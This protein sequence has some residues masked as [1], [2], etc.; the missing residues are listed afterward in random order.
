MKCI[1]ALLV[2]LVLVS[3]GVQA[4]QQLPREELPITAGS[5]VKIRALATT[6]SQAIRSGT[7]DLVI[8]QSMVNM[9]VAAQKADDT[10]MRVATAMSATAV[11]HIRELMGTP[12]I[13][14]IMATTQ[15]RIGMDQAIG[16]KMMTVCSHL[17]GTTYSTAI[18]VIE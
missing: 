6:V 1:K 18:L 12:E 7:S 9:G 13:A 14:E 15:P 17:V 5:C 8:L 4:Y 16:L 3:G 10:D 11:G 2:V